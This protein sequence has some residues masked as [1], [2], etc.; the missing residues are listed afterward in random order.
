M[1]EMSI[2]FAVYFYSE[3][4]PSISPST[5]IKL[6]S[7]V[8]WFMLRVMSAFGWNP[9]RWGGSSCGMAYILST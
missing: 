7:V 2:F 9:K 4:T 1:P 8:A 6:G 5:N 3:L